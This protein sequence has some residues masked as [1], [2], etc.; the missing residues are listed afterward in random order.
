MGPGVVASSAGE[1]SPSVGILEELLYE[2]GGVMLI[3]IYSVTVCVD[4]PEAFSRT[5]GISAREMF[6]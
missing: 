5:H 1:S 2:S 6:N 4:R 3:V